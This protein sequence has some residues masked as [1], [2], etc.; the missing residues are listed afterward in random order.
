MQ[1]LCDQAEREDRER[2]GRHHIRPPHD[3]RRSFKLRDLVQEGAGDANDPSES[4]S[5]SFERI[6]GLNMYKTVL[7]GGKPASVAAFG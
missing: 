6:A 7:A 2:D 4:I 5:F 3:R 1:S